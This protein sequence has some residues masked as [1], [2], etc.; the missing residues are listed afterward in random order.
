[1]VN[2]IDSYIKK[3][4]GRNGGERRTKAY[5]FAED[6]VILVQ[7]SEND[8]VEL[9]KVIKSCKVQGINIPMYIDYK[10]DGEK[11]WILEELAPGKEL[12]SLAESEDATKIWGNMPYEHIEKYVKDVYLLQENGIG[13]EPRRRNIFYDS[14]KGFTTIDVALLSNNENQDAL[15]EVDYFFKMFAPVF[16]IPFSDDEYGQIVKDKMILNVMK[17]FECGHPF[18]AKYKRWIYRGNSYYADFLKNHGIDLNLNEEE[19]NLLIGYIN[20]LINSIVQDKIDHPETLFYNNNIGY[21]D[22]LNSSIAY[23]PD[24]NLF[25]LKEQTLEK[26][27][28]TTVYNKIKSLFLNNQ[29]DD[30]LR[31]LYF[32]IRRKELDP[33][34]IYPIDYLDEQI[35]TEIMSM[36]TKIK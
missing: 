36:N 32:K 22:L 20:T 19:Y 24:F 29:D 2:S 4:K 35:E 11:Y 3:T 17:A 14:N 27:V 18:F 16:L 23:C 13:V 30:N 34:S 9:Q 7:K 21:I 26:Y 25:N 15:K 33:V 28:E 31:N 8:F 12:Q 5:V 1:M 10:Y 6:N